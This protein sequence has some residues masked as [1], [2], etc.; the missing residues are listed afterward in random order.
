MHD[1][2]PIKFPGTEILERLETAVTPMF[3][4]AFVSYT[5][6][7]RFWRAGCLVWIRTLRCLTV[8]LV[9]KLENSGT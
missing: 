5:S 6:S 8:A 1:Y 4:I 7:G 3:S 2:H 9:F